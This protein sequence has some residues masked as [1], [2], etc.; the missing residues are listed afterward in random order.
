M[1]Y[2]RGITV[3]LRPATVDDLPAFRAALDTE[4]VARWWHWPDPA[5]DLAD[6]EQHQLAITVK[7]ETVGMIQ[8]DEETDPDFRHASIDVFVHPDQHRLGYGTDA[9]VT[10]ARWLTDVRGHHRLTIDPA[11]ENEPAIACYRRLGF[12]PVGVLRQQWF[13]HRR[14]VWAD[15]L[16]LD[17]LKGE[18]SGELTGRLSNATLNDATLNDGS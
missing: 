9:I 4:E 3:T 18:L 5:G 17:L 8:W 14:G 16:L 1:D 12:H 13:D 11:A 6:P 15:G 7:G 10:L 2:L